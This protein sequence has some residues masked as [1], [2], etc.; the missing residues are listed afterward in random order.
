MIVCIWHRAGLYGGEIDHVDVGSWKRH[1]APPERG[2]V[3]AVDDAPGEAVR[4]CVS[5][6]TKIQKNKTKQKSKNRK[7]SD[8]QEMRTELFAGG[9]PVH[10]E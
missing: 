4:D 1:D 10:D 7:L 3:P 9:E 8:E 6:Q 5:R 2:N